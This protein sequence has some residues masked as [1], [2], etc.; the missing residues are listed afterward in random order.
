[1]N[2]GRPKKYDSDEERTTA[3]I[4]SSIKNRT[5]DNPKKD[6][7]NWNRDDFIK[8]YLKQSRVCEYCGLTEDE[9]IKIHKIA[10]ER[11]AGRME[12]KGNPFEIDRFKPKKPYDE[13]NCR[14]ACYWCN[15]AKTDFFDG[16]EFE[17][18][19]KAI[20]KALRSIIKKRKITRP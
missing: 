6:I 16:K 5:K 13:K 11:G 17:P 18:I 3:N 19:G 4:Y 7:S 20:G 8:W 15:N 1:M 10:K 14:L 9:K 2:R 12:L